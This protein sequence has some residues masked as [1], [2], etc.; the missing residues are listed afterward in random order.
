MTDEGESWVE[1][2]EDFD[3]K[4]YTSGEKLVNKILA[5]PN[6]YDPS[7]GLFTKRA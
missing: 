6:F 5:I 4:I 3:D 2:G 1:F 7:S